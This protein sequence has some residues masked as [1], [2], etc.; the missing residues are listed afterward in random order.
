[1]KEKVVLNQNLKKAG[2]GN[3]KEEEKTDREA[4]AIRGVG[5]PWKLEEIEE[6]HLQETQESISMKTRGAEREKGEVRT[7]REATAIRGRPPWPPGRPPWPPGSTCCG[8]T[9]GGESSSRPRRT[10]TTRP[11]WTAWRPRPPTSHR[12]YSTSPDRRHRSSPCQASSRRIQIR[13]MQGV[14]KQREKSFS[15]SKTWKALRD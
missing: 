15:G 8:R 9:P 14:L 11:P 13:T 10:P 12:N 1:M 4:T 6:G 3:E 2:E 7:G 5:P